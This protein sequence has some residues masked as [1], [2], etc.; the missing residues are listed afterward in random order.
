MRKWFQIFSIFTAVIILLTG[1]YIWFGSRA[2]IATL[3]HVPDSDWSDAYKVS[4]ELKGNSYS[5]IIDAQG[6]I[7]T[8]WLE[9]RPPN[10]AADLM[11]YSATSRGKK[12]SDAQIIAINDQLEEFT[13]T[14]AND[15]LHIFYIGQGETDQADLYYIQMDLSGEILNNRKVVS[16]LFRSAGN[17]QAHPTP[18]GN[19]MLVWSDQVDL[20]RQIKTM[21]VSSDGQVMGKPNQV[22]FGE[23]DARVPKLLIDDKERYHLTWREEYATHCELVYQSLTN[24]GVSGSTPIHIDQV[25][26]NPASMGVYEDSLYLVWT[27]WEYKVGPRFGVIEKSFPNYELFGTV[28]DINH[29]EEELQIQRLTTKNG[30]SYEHTMGI[31]PEGNINL[32]Y[33]DTYKTHLGLTHRVFK[34]DFLTEV[35]KAR[36]LFPNQIS[37]SQ[38]NLLTDVN[39]QFRLVWMETSESGGYVFYANTAHPR[40]ANILEV[41]GINGGNY[42]V[43]LFMSLFYLLAAP[44][45]F[46]VIHLHWVG[47]LILPN[48]VKNASETLSSRFKNSTWAS[49]LNKPVVKVSL[50]CLFQ[51]LIY[52]AFGKASWIFGFDLPAMSQILFIL[53]VAAIATI[54]LVMLT[55][56]TFRRFGATQIGFHVFI[57]MFWV[58]LMGL[59]YSLP[60]INFFFEM[61]DI[62]K[63]IG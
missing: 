24:D 22:T 42:G 34:D 12:R 50:A 5:S 48:F 30:P 7:H 38:T 2:D 6:N 47:F 29:P 17:L 56:D 54:A 59:T 45:V 33:I 13:S 16:N 55:K 21:L 20:Y 14:F 11:H 3:S 61:I 57:F 49:Y 25:S 43:S 31:D 41:V 58:H 26:V 46:M 9:Y 35:K 37:G 36:R 62:G 44:I 18:D 23:L 40:A 15:R 51:L 19:L 60:L 10:G 63:F 39:G 52:V 28:L 4:P 1:F 53:I 8:F 27:R 32:V